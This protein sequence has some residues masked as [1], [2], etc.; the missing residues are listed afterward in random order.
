MLISLQFTPLTLTDELYLVAL[1]ALLVALNAPAATAES[2]EV[3]LTPALIAITRAAGVVLVCLASA[4]IAQAVLYTQTERRVL[5]GDLARAD[6][7]YEAARKFPMPGPNLAVSKQFA[8]MAP[9]L[10]ALDRGPAYAAA[11]EAAAVAE[12]G[13]AERFNALYQSAVLAIMTRNLPRAESKLRAAIDAAPVWYRPRMALASVLWWEGR[14]QDAERE[15][16]LA[17][18]CAGSMEPFVRQTLN[19]A[20]A[21]ASAL[22]GRI[23]P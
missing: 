18:N 21:Q 6:D 1:S 9:R 3:I 14:D 7:S 20:R 23:A 19:G 15:G 13:N 10:Q 12:L 5:H 11:K 16:A 8:S 22:Q 2:S 17:L 4:Y